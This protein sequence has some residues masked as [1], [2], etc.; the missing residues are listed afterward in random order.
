MSTSSDAVPSE[1]GATAANVM[2]FP[3][4]LPAS[5][6][7]GAVARASG[8]ETVDGAAGDGGML[9]TLAGA[10][11]GARG[12]DTHNW[13]LDIKALD[14]PSVKRVL[15]DNK[16]HVAEAMRKSARGFTKGSVP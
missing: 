4:A 5:V 11:G 9:Q 16:E 13:N 6:G 12:G 10:I 15:L 14:G 1:G 7:A 2:Q 8:S 3:T